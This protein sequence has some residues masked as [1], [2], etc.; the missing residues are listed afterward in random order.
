VPRRPTLYVSNDNRL[1]KWRSGGIFSPG[2][3]VNDPRGKVGVLAVPE[4]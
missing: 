1:N 2:G 4:K 3:G